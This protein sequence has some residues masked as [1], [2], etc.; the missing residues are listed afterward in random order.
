M[1]FQSNGT[2]TYLRNNKI[3]INFSKDT[4]IV[5][6]GWP[7]FRLPQV[8]YNHNV[9]IIGSQDAGHLLLLLDTATNSFAKSVA[10]DLHPIF[11]KGKIILQIYISDHDYEI[12]ETA[13]KI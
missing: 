9:M 13:I 4:T 3:M 8:Y 6:F 12:Y 10:G 5:A 2:L 1:L 7:S 11:L